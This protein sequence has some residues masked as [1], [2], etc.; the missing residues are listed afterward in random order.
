MNREILNKRKK[1]LG[2]ILIFIALLFGV[3]FNWITD[4]H[5]LQL[6]SIVGYKWMMTVLLIVILILFYII[7]AQNK[8]PSKN[9]QL[10]EQTCPK[11]G[12][13]ALELI[14]STVRKFE[15]QC[16]ECGTKHYTFK[17]GQTNKIQESQ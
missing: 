10:V 2:F 17:E 16:A 1:L 14:K 11:C 6:E 15:Y 12:K 9:K 8:V 13:K 4:E 3:I 5:F 7:V